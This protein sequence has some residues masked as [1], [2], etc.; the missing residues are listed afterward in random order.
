MKI[1]VQ[2]EANTGVMVKRKARKVEGRRMGM[3]GK[4]MGRK[5]ERRLEITMVDTK[6]DKELMHL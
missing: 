4:M 5:K 1:Q 6:V 3:E 2:G